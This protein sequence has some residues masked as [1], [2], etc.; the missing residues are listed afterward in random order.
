V[1]GPVPPPPPAA[2]AGLRA[3]RGIGAAIARPLHEEDSRCRSACATRRRSAAAFGEHDHNARH[4]R[5]LDALEPPDR[6]RGS[7]RPWP[8]RALD[9]L[10]NN[11]GIYRKLSSPTARSVSTRSGRHVKAPSG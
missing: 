8:L 2:R 9:A 11:A 1:S 4:V 5:S 10:I 6:G 7:R 3:S